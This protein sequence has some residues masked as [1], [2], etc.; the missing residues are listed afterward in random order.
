MMLIGDIIHDSKNNLQLP[1]ATEKTIY[2][3]SMPC[4]LKDLCLGA[5]TSLTT[6]GECKGKQLKEKSPRFRLVNYCELSQ[7]TPNEIAWLVILKWDS[8]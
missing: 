3:A 4:Q 7:F 8:T 5:T 6:D 1:K 2:N